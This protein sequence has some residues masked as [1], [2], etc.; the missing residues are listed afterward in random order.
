MLDAPLSQSGAVV[1][2]AISNDEN[3]PASNVTDGNNHTYWMTTGLMPQ[4]LTITFPQIMDIKDVRIYCFKGINLIL[5]DLIAKFNVI[6]I[7]L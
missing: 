5:L 7:R 4:S 1:S 6:F 2:V 3:H